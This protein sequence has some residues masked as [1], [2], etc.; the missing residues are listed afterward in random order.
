MLR[1][2]T[3]QRIVRVVLVIAMFAGISSSAADLDLKAIKIEL[4]KEIKWVSNPNAGSEVATLVGDPSKPGIYVV[5][6]K[7]LPH[8]NSR[9]IFIRTTV[10]SR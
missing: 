5:L 9:P 7:W 2:L 4:P 3:T 1:F 10:T 6:Q 8:H